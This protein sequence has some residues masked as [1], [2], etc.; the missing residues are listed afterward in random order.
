MNGL[1]VDIYIDKEH[2]FHALNQDIVFVELLP[3]SE[4]LELSK[5]R[6]VPINGVGVRE[7]PTGRV[8]FIEDGAGRDGEFYCV[9]ELNQGASDR[10]KKANIQEDE[11]EIFAETDAPRVDVTSAIVGNQKSGFP[12]RARCLDQKT[13]WLFL[14]L[15]DLKKNPFELFGA[16]PA[17][18]TFTIDSMQIFP[19]KI[20]AWPANA[21]NPV[22]TISGPCI[23]RAGEPMTEMR[24]ILESH[25]MGQHMEEFS[26]AVKDEV[27]QV[28]QK[29]KDNME[30]EIAARVDLRHLRI[31]TIDPATAR[32]LDD[33]VHMNVLP[34]AGGPGKNHY[35]FGVHIADVSHFVKEGS[36]L[37]QQAREKCLTAYL[38]PR[39]F[40]MLPPA[41]A[42]NLCSLNP[43]EN[44]FAYSAIFR[45]DHNGEM[46]PKPKPE[47]DIPL[48]PSLAI[49]DPPGTFTPRFFR[50][51]IRSV[52]RWNYEQAQEV[53]DGRDIA[54]EH[55]PQVVAPW[56]WADVCT[57]IQVL[58]TIT[59]KIRAYRFGKG[60]FRLDKIKLRFEFSDTEHPMV[61]SGYH[62]EDHSTSHELVEELM[63]LANKVV[64]EKIFFSPL[65]NFGVL[66]NHFGPKHNN[67]QKFIS[68]LHAFKMTDLSATPTSKDIHHLIATT[69]KKYGPAVMFCV[70][71]MLMRTMAQAE[72]FVPQSSSLSSVVEEALSEPF[73]FALNF[74]FYSHFTSPIRRYPDILL[75]RGL[76][77]VL[78]AEAEHYKK[79]VAPNQNPTKPTQYLSIADS[80]AK[81]QF[82]IDGPMYR[83][84]CER[85]NLM[86]KASREM[87]EHADTSFFAMT[88]RQPGAKPKYTLGYCFDIMDSTLTLYVPEL[89]ATPKI[90]FKTV[91]S[92][93]CT[94][95]MRG[96]N[97]FV[98]Y[99]RKINQ[100]QS[101][102]AL[103]DFREG[104]G[105]ED[106][107]KDLTLADFE[108]RKDG[109]ITRI[110]LF[111][112]IPL[113]CV[114]NA[115]AP[116]CAHFFLVSPHDRQYKTLSDMGRKMLLKKDDTPYEQPDLQSANRMIPMKSK[117]EKK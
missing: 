59:Q 26:E 13:P 41:L 109:M 62:Y 93:P 66:R 96:F 34:N 103:V 9:I 73:H 36:A 75:H 43:N 112:P 113:I 22:G 64:A 91:Q 25:C 108:S 56:T 90:G 78:V 54:V 51:V 29:Y 72:Y 7:M 3:R 97:K 76:S 77:A 105:D 110:D 99:P 28:L 84:E 44:K 12:L 80:D 33:A 39:A 23:G 49:V 15:N 104:A 58:D 117:D 95:I 92:N 102:S 68:I 21:T 30:E 10:S 8:V 50:S 24:Y 55:R 69:E 87:Q 53:I 114:P 111:T 40:H 14:E 65:R 82:G 67:F 18:D 70:Q 63:L 45:V 27:E 17:K 38:P 4:W 79:E 35:E 48:N 31:M 61:P 20:K 98:K 89:N 106:K 74:D 115:S 71:I 60:G 86:K 101:F 85:N 47:T 37:D 42:A 107:S 46:L 19:V 16:S 32:D 88:L 94:D 83:I 5:D 11:T 116:I 2:R 57:D 81:D 52:C 1:D 100:I 6:N